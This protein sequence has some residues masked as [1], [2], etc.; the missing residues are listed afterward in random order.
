MTVTQQVSSWIRRF[1]LA[2][3]EGGEFFAPVGAHADHHQRAQLVPNGSTNKLHLISETGPLVILRPAEL[4]ACPLPGRLRRCIFR[5]DV[6]SKFTL[7]RDLSVTSFH[8]M[9]RRY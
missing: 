1:A 5:G 4:S 6:E 8:R 3:D 2:I 7:Q 9:I